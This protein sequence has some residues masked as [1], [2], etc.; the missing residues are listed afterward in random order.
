MAQQG[1]VMADFSTNTPV[2]LH[3]V[4][5]VQATKE[6][7]VCLEECGGGTLSSGKPCMKVKETLMEHTEVK[8]FHKHSSGWDNWSSQ[9]HASE[10]ELKF[11]NSKPLPRWTPQQRCA[12]RI[13]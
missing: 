2:Q 3:A 8:P 1:A 10:T 11:Q 9:L 13:S 12:E 6:M 4:H 5:E 7:C